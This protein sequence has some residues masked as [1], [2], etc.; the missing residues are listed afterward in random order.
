MEEMFCTYISFQEKIDKSI[1]SPFDKRLTQTIQKI[2][3]QINNEN[4]MADDL[5]KIE[6]ILAKTKNHESLV[7][8]H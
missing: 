2:I 6:K 3:H 8:S 4:K 7:I 1:L 5:K